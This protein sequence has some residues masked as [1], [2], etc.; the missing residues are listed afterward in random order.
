[1]KTLVRKEYATVCNLYQVTITEDYVREINRVLNQNYI[2]A[3]GVKPEITE[4]DIVDAWEYNE[5]EKLASI[6]AIGWSRGGE[7]HEYRRGISLFD[8]LRDTLSDDMWCADMEEIDYCTSDFEDT[9]ED[10]VENDEE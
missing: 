5:T 7:T 4:Q 2:Y 10:T 3:N 9:V 6:E 1:M 8:L